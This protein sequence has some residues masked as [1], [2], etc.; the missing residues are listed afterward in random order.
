MGACADASI[1]S[2]GMGPRNG[3]SVEND[4]LIPVFPDDGDTNVLIFKRQGAVPIAREEEPAGVDM[5]TSPMPGSTDWIVTP[6]LK[7]T[8]SKKETGMHQNDMTE[9]LRRAKGLSTALLSLTFALEEAEAHP[10]IL[11]QFHTAQTQLDYAVEML[12]RYEGC[13]RDTPSND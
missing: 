11:H 6:K 7:Y 3:K 2:L 12:Q 10:E 4:S 13:R 1:R 5:K 8:D 9:E